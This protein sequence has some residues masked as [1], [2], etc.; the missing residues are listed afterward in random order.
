M[1]NKINN[2]TVIEDKTSSNRHALCQCICGTIKLVLKYKIK[3]GDSTSCGCKKN[4]N[5]NQIKVGGKFYSWLVQKIEGSKAFS[6]CQPCGIEKWVQIG[7][8]ISGN[9]KS[10]GC[11]SLQLEAS[12]NRSQQLIGLTFGNWKV[13]EFVSNN[14]YYLKCL[15]IS[16]GKASRILRKD[17]LTKQTRKS[18]GC[19]KALNHRLTCLKK[20]G[21]S[22]ISQIPAVKI[23]KKQTTLK[24]Y[25]VE[26][27]SQ[28]PEIALRAAK[29]VNQH[30]IKRHWKTEEEVVCTGGWEA[31][32][33]DY[34]NRNRIDFLWQPKTFKL[35]AGNTYRPDLY[36]IKDD[37][38]IEIKGWWRRDS[39]AKWDEF[40]TQIQSN[41][42]LWNK[43][44]LKELKIL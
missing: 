40:H 24:N 34:L 9:S 31:K 21:T 29:K 23:K 39:K 27:A 32:V 25:G 44:K 28:S 26:Y 22:Y 2:W 10:C 42:E 7:S 18:C 16:C 3:T 30:Y 35:A 17:E 12:R 20:Y 38:W 14:T 5:L 36:L 37:K 11:L 33:A 4:K 1:K 13:L 15:C 19:Q 8:L 6:L 43:E 41:S